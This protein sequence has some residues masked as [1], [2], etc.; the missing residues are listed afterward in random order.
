MLASLAATQRVATQRKAVE[1]SK[2][3][4]NSLNVCRKQAVSAAATKRINV[5][6]SR[7]AQSIRNGFASSTVADGATNAELKHHR[8]S[9]SH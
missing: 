5:Q 6:V 1:R 9:R 7:L 3:C 8:A 4:Y 2:S